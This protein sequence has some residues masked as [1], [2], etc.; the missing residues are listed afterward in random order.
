MAV[1]ALTLQIHR[2]QTFE[3]CS[4]NDHWDCGVVNHSRY[5]EIHGVPVAAIGIAGYALLAVL[6]LAGRRLL[7]LVAAL[8]GLGFALRLTNIEA[9]V[10][11]LW[12]IYC[13]VSQTLIAVITLLAAG[14][15]MWGRRPRPQPLRAPFP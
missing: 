5:A 11:Q 10:L 6:A 3:P 12:C 8:I 4:V 9:H 15:L 2:S 1:S 13:V 14:W 7:V